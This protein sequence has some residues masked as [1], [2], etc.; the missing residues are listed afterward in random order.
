MNFDLSNTREWF[1]PAGASTKEV[2]KVVDGQGRVIWRKWY[3]VSYDDN[4]DETQYWTI[5]YYANGGRGSMSPDSVAKGAAV[6][7]A[8]SQ[9]TRGGYEFGG[10]NTAPGGGGT[11]YPDRTSFTPASDIALYAQW[12]ASTHTMTFNANGGSG[13]MPPLE[14][15][16]YNSWVTIPA[17]AFSRM[18]YEFSEW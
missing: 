6:T 13:S 15:I 16:P 7:L 10:W 5:R 4:L 17:C 8:P 1:I 12:T 9:F 18:G 2:F 3:K 11:A 14:N